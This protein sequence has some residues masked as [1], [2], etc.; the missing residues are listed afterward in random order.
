MVIMKTAAPN[1]VPRDEL[2]QA[3]EQVLSAHFKTPRRI[4]HL[5]RRISAYSSSCT[6]ENLDVTMDRGQKLSLVLKDLSPGSRLAA[7]KRCGPLSSTN[8]GENWRF[9][10]ESCAPA[11]MGQPS[12]TVQSSLW[13]GSGIG[14]SLSG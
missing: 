1:R 7:A 13:T 4:K 10:A 3:L 2:R 5:R 8:H 11:S 6:I 14:C 9:T 12:A